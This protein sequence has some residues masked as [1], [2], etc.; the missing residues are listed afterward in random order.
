[1]LAGCPRGGKTKSNASILA[2][3]AREGVSERG[4]VTH[5][6][7]VSSQEEREI[8]RGEAAVQVEAHLITRVVPTG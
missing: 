1:M 4:I 6:N 2:E 7:E 3:R 5:D 8:E